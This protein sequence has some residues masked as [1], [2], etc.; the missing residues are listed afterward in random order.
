MRRTDLLQPRTSSYLLLGD[1][2]QKAGGKNIA[3]AHNQDE[4]TSTQC[5]L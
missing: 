2:R 5:E 4:V 1:I 3:K